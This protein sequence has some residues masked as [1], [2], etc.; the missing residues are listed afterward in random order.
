VDSLFSEKGTTRKIGILAIQ[1]LRGLESCQSGFENPKNSQL[2]HNML[3][4]EKRQVEGVW[5]PALE[6]AIH[7]RIK[8]RISVY[9]RKMGTT[10][11]ID[12]GAVAHATTHPYPCEKG[13]T[14]KIY[15]LNYNS[16][17][18][19]FSIFGYS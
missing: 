18:N 4:G 12:K 6:Q 5:D 7:L 16:N 15:L 1:A 13:L 3:S 19:P 9:I 11:K 2:L 10:R 17:S 8:K 14:R